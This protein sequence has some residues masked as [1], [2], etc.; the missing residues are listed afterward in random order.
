MTNEAKRQAL[1]AYEIEV[2]CIHEMLKY[3]DE[4]A[5]EKAGTE[6]AFVEQDECFE[7]DPFTCLKMSYDYLKSI[8]YN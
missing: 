4:E 8:G 5:F 1:A 6:V 7:R 2:E 3:F